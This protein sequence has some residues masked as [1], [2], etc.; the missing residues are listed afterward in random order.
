MIMMELM[1][2][3]MYIFTKY[4]VIVAT[5][6]IDK[7][8]WVNIYLAVMNQYILINNVIDSWHGTC[9]MQTIDHELFLR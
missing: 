2:L 1:L 9:G 8:N 3:L 5:K 6:E 7:L 4:N